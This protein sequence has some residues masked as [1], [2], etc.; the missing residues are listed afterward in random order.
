MTYFGPAAC[1]IFDSVLSFHF[2]LLANGD[3]I[4]FA[5]DI[6]ARRLF[7]S[8][9]AGFSIVGLVGLGDLLI[10]TVTVVV[11]IGGRLGSKQS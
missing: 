5:P 2:D 1:T 11:G 10:A 4:L 7:D 3:T 8:S 6:A 9:K